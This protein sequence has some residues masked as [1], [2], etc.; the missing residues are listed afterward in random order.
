VLKVRGNVD[1]CKSLAAEWRV[2]QQAMMDAAEEAGDYGGRGLHSSSSQL[3]QS[4]I[5]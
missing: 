1:K 2:Q 4:N 5:L 3:N